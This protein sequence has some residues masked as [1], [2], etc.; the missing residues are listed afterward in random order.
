MSQDQI[1]NASGREVLHFYTESQ[2]RILNGRSF[3]KSQGMFTS[4]KNND[5]SIV[6]YMF[7]SENLLSEKNE[8]KVLPLIFL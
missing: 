6:D 3:V 7:V 4:Y 2:L 5:N 8:F 1:S